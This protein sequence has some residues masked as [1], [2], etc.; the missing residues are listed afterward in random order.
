VYYGNPGST[1]NAE[2][3]RLANGGTYPARQDFKDQ[4]GAAQ[5]W[6]AARSVYLGK[7]TDVVGVLN[8]IYWN[9]PFV[10]AATTAATSGVY[11]AGTTGAD[12]GNGVG[13]TI[14]APSN[15]RLV[16]DGHTISTGE[17][18]LYWKNTD[19]KTNGV[20]YVT[21]QGS[22]STKWV[23][24]RDTNADNHIA[25][26]LQKDKY[27]YVSNGAT[28]ATQRFVITTVGTGPSA[29]VV[30]GTQNIDFAVTTNIVYDEKKWLDIAGICNLIAGTVGFEPSTSL[31][32]VAN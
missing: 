3:N 14:T 13:A 4:G 1:T 16:V 11:A 30:I 25:G 27:I 21:D 28:Y 8:K 29:S 32:Q 12:G 9:I 19:A 24:T 7:T 6:A 20:Y 18:V 5:A 17:R 26:Q 15:A 2:L 23:L 31:A 10:H 22:A